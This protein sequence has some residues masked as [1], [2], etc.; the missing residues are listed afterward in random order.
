[1]HLLE[2][3]S[4]PDT[5]AAPPDLHPQSSWRGIAVAVLCMAIPSAL[6]VYSLYFTALDYAQA[7]AVTATI[8][9]FQ[10]LYTMVLVVTT[11]T[12]GCCIGR[13]RS[14]TTVIPVFHALW[15]RIYTVVLFVVI[16]AALMVSVLEIRRMPCGVYTGWPREF[17]AFHC[18]YGSV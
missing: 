10:V 15:Y 13:G 14:D 16:L 12:M 17:D 8:V 1:M 4:D 6:L 11:A 9:A 7:A 5:T 3:A 18:R 2:A